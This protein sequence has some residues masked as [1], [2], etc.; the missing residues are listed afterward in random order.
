M[1]DIVYVDFK[2][3]EIKKTYTAYRWKCGHCKARFL[4][5]SRFPR[6]TIHIKPI[7]QIGNQ[8]VELVLCENCVE[9]FYN[10]II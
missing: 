7:V 4:Y 2:K 1:G 9:E 6:N 3:K 8:K 10:A 5:D